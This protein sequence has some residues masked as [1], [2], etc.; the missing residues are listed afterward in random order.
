MPV[1]IDNQ[2]SLW[3]NA[4]AEADF[5]NVRVKRSSDETPWDDVLPQSFPK[6]LENPDTQ[7]V[8]IKLSSIL[9]LEKAD[10]TFDFAISAGEDN[11]QESDYFIVAGKEIDF[12]LP[13]APTVGG[14]R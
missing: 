1:V 11:G 7:E 8:E 12:L 6:S 2:K 5:Y 14:I 9:D 4:I 3:F 13:A 10:D